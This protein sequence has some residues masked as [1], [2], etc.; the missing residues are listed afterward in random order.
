VLGNDRIA[1][2]AEGDRLFGARAAFV[3]LW[4]VEWQIG[5]EMGRRGDRLPCFGLP[6]RSGDESVPI[7]PNSLTPIVY[8]SATLGLAIY[9]GQ[10]QTPGLSQGDFVWVQKT[11]AMV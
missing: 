3:K 11:I 4:R 5:L 6:L 10:Q 9:Y 8:E 7:D 1:A 2:A